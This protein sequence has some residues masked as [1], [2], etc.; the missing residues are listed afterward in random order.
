MR[1]WYVGLP[2]EDH[3]SLVYRRPAGADDTATRAL[4]KF[5]LVLQKVIVA[6]RPRNSR[7]LWNSKVQ[8]RVCKACA[9]RRDSSSHPPTLRFISILSSHLHFG[10]PNGFPPS[11]FRLKTAYAL[12]VSPW[13]LRVL[14]TSSSSISSLQ[15]VTSGLKNAQ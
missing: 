10:I 1:K 5:W 3:A 9:E 12:L 14:P 7:L 4:A 15:R 2:Q 13:E 6:D 8:C 11:G